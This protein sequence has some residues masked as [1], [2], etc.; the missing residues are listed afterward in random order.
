LE[1][2]CSGADTSHY[3]PVSAKN[4]RTSK[5]CE[6]ADPEEHR[7]NYEKRD[8]QLNDDPIRITGEEEKEETTEQ[9]AETNTYESTKSVF[10]GPMRYNRV[11]G[12]AGR[13]LQVLKAEALLTS[14]TNGARRRT[15]CCLTHALL[16]LLVHRLPL[17]RICRNFPSSVCLI[18]RAN[19]IS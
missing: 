2:I 7:T 4:T 9:Y 11:A 8:G 13:M 5:T 6:Q 18:F 19:N 3:N 12:L 15:A 14:W 16:L 10:E 1:R 17:Y